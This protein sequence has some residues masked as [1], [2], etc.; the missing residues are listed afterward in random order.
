MAERTKVAYEVSFAPT[1]AAYARFGRAVVELGCELRDSYTF[2]AGTVVTLVHMRPDQSESFRTAVKPWD[3]RYY[4]PR[5][6]ENG[7]LH[8]KY[9]SPEDEISCKVT[10]A[11]RRIIAAVEKGE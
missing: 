3:M 7:T 8:A 11:A 5:V 1:N 4:P 10:E 6:F 9:A 2:L